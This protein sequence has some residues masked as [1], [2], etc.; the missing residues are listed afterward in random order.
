M[1][2]NRTILAGNLTRDPE[3]RTTASGVIVGKFGL[4]VNEYAGKD[5]PKRTTFVNLTAFG[6]T[7]EV[8]GE[9]F[10]KGDPIHIE[11]RLDFSE[12]TDKAGQKRTALGVVVDSF[13]FVGGKA[14]AKQEGGNAAPF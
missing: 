10:K 11:G 8:I 1:N 12:W 7:A 14:D 3:I 13:Q 9:H 6:R 4:A 5:K 2:Y